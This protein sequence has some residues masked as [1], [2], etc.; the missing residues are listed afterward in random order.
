MIVVV[1]MKGGA[2]SDAGDPEIGEHPET[3]DMLLDA[4]I[5]E[6]SNTTILVTLFREYTKKVNV[7]EAVMKTGKGK[8]AF[9]LILLLIK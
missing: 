8:F 7:K 1:T 2:N 5:W 9:M 3:K 4:S 6:K